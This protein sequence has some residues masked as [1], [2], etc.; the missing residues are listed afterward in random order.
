M[1]T[2]EPYVTYIPG[3]KFGIDPNSQSWFQFT[4]VIIPDGPIDPSMGTFN[5]WGSPYA[6]G[7]LFAMCDGSVHVAAY[8][9]P[10]TIV[11]NMLTPQG[12]EVYTPP[13]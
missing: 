2:S 5:R 4:F 10:N 3:N 8:S 12:G 9:T 7:S 1:D 6:G 11:I 13:W